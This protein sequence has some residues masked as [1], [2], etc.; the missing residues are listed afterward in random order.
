M[1]VFIRKSINILFILVLFPVLSVASEN[2]GSALPFVK[3]LTDC[4]NKV[5]PES[6]V[7]KSEEE[8]SE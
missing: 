1:F 5:V 7:K 3:I 4:F 2:D 8:S 6:T